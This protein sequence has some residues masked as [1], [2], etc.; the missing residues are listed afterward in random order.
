MFRNIA[1]IMILA[2]CLAAMLAMPAMATTFYGAPVGDDAPLVVDA[3]DYGKA[4]LYN[5]GSSASASSTP[6]SS[7]P[8]AGYSY[9]PYPYSGLNRYAYNYNP[10]YY[11]YNYGSYLASPY[12][13]FSLNFGYSYAYSAYSYPSYYQSYAYY[14][15]YA[16]SA[17]SYYAPSYY[18][19]AAYVS[20]INSYA[21]NY[22]PEPNYAAPV[23]TIPAAPARSSKLSLYSYS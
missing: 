6:T 18:T 3:A 16:Y 4:N 20:G 14:T 11:G 10:G 1:K 22:N 21:Y 7:T 23:Y 8:T 2:L 12:T 9:T 5:Y 17:Y 19:P 13:G 15:P